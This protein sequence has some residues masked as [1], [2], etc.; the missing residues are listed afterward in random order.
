MLHIVLLPIQSRLEIPL[1]SDTASKDAS[2]DKSGPTIKSIVSEHDGFQVQD[3]HCRIVADDQAEIAHVVE[4]WCRSGSL[5]W[6]ITTGGTGF[7]VRD[8]TPEVNIVPVVGFYAIECFQYPGH[9]TPHRT[10]CS[11]SRPSHDFLI[12]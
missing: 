4:E 5:D 6:V 9:Y 8:F 1:V 10:T 12:P 7:G 11:R 3:E 2:A